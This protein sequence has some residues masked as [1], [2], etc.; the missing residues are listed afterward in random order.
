MST[1]ACVVSR[2]DTQR[3]GKKE[4]HFARSGR[5]EG[6]GAGRGSGALAEIELAEVEIGAKIEQM[7]SALFLFFLSFFLLLHLSHLTLHFLFV[8]FLFLSP[9]P[10]P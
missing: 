4:R 7:V 6:S 1:N 10:L 8:L 2:E 3:R 9:K 5:R